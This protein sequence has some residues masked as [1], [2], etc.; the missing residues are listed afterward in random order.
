MHLQRLE[1]LGDGLVRGIALR[2]LFFRFP[3][4]N[5]S[6]LILA[7]AHLGMNDTFVK[8]FE[9]SGLQ[10]FQEKLAYELFEEAIDGQKAA[11]QG[12]AEQQQQSPT[13][14]VESRT[15]LALRDQGTVP[16]DLFEAYLAYVHI[17]HGPQV[18][19]EW[20]AALAEPWIR[21][22][23]NDAAFID[24][25][26]NVTDAGAVR[27]RHEGRFGR[28]RQR[29]PNSAGGIWSNLSGWMFGRRS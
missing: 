12:N 15:Q 23:E 9:I 28:R 1:L 24:N 3:N 27:I 6:G 19:E 7:A 25:P 22:I 20:F 16:A 11:L 10:E 17:V 21:R 5:S 8:M 29:R 2:T 14:V 4:M 13:N 18:A 26:K